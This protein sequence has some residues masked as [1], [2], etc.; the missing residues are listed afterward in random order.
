LLRLLPLL[1][2]SSLSYAHH[3]RYSFI[4]FLVFSLFWFVEQEQKQ[5]EKIRKRKRRRQKNKGEV[6]ET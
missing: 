4:I 3:A 2:A 6:N 5:K 1:V